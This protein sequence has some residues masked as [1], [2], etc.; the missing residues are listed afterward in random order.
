MAGFARCGRPASRRICR[1]PGRACRKRSAPRCDGNERPAASSVR[2]ASLRCHAA[3]SPHEPVGM[4]AASAA[5]RL[6]TS[7]VSNSPK[8]VAPDPDIRASAAPWPGEL[9]KARVPMAGA[10]PAPGL[11]DRCAELQPGGCQLENRCLR[12]SGAAA[13][14]CGGKRGEHV[15]RR[16][17]TPGL[18]S[19]SRQRRKAGKR[20][21]SFA[22]A[23][24]QQRLA[25][26][27]IGSRPRATARAAPDRPA[28]RPPVRRPSP[29]SAAAASLEP[30]PMP[31]ATGRFFSSVMR[32]RRTV[33]AGRAPR[34]AGRAPR[35]PDCVVGRH[36]ARQSGRIRQSASLSA[37]SRSRPGRRGAVNTARLSIR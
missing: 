37:A 4:A 35:P 23:A 14:C 21:D 25:A 33:V 3:A 7:P 29:R 36:R 2:H 30:P 8:Q 18:T 27:H 34:A 13:G 9:R 31:E 12:G 17:A 5:A 19:T 32:D 6:A 15:R 16:T 22:D 24:R 28:R 11:R 26:R 1:R 10:A 20:L